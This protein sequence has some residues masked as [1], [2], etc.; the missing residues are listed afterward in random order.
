M[1]PAGSTEIC[2]LEVLVREPV[3]ISYRRQTG[4][5][6]ANLV[7]SELRRRGYI[8]FLDVHQPEAGRF[9][10][11]IQAAIRSSRALVLICT[12]ES[13]V[14]Q[15]SGTDWVGREIEEALAVKCPIVPFFATDFVRQR[16]LPDSIVRALEYNGVAMDAQ[17]PDATFDRLSMLLGPSRRVSMIM[18]V[19]TA[20]AVVL[21]AVLLWFTSTRY[22]AEKD[23]QSSFAKV[24]SL[25]LAG[26]WP[27]GSNIKIGFSNGFVAQKQKVQ[28][29][30]KEWLR[31]ANMTYT[32]SEK[33]IGDVRI[34]FSANKMA[35]WSFRGTE[36]HDVP[37]TCPTMTLVGIANDSTIS[38]YDRAVILH[39]FGHVLGLLDEIQ[40]PNAKIPWRP[41]IRANAQATYVYISQVEECPAPLNRH[42]TFQESLAHY[43]PFDP[44]SIMMALIPK[45][46]LTE[47]VS[48]GGASELSANDK[49][50]V[51]RLYPKL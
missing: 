26:A 22:L 39:E 42:V 27:N 10:E 48:Y 50:F 47:D 40:N 25:A 34:F 7:A 38:T 31:Y 6:L 8:T 1:L 44:T 4:H 17:F 15:T 23:L 16:E 36:A 49:E 2:I 5:Q 21:I 30:A 3:F 46:Y 51:A 14:T 18:L 12:N 11:Q 35:S 24:K 45:E 19:S 43:H 28:Q 37:P 13:F 33:P 29:I 41:E 32:F 9:W 20:A